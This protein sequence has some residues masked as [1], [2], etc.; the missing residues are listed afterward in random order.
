MAIDS[1]PR[2]ASPAA[3]RRRR[4]FAVEA[5]A[6][7]LLAGVAVFA[8]TEFAA[9]LFRESSWPVAAWWPSTAVAVLILVGVRPRYWALVSAAIAIGNAGGNFAV[10]TSAGLAVTFG[11]ANGVEAVIAVGV[12]RRVRRDVR[13]PAEVARLLFS[14]LT[15]VA[16][17]GVV[18]AARAAVVGGGDARRLVGELVVSHA[19]GLIVLA[20]ALLVRPQTTE[21]WEGLRRGRRRNAEWALVF[22]LTAVLTCWLFF[23]E[24]DRGLALLL[25]VP[26]VYAAVRLTP[27][28]VLSVVVLICTLVTAG[29]VHGDGVVAL[30]DGSAERLWSLRAVVAVCCLISLFVSLNAHARVTVRARLRD[31][32]RLVALAFDSAPSGMYIASLDPERAGEL[33]NVNAALCELLM[34]PREEL[35]GKHIDVLAPPDDAALARSRIAKMVGR[36][37]ADESRERELLRADGRRLPTREAVNVVY[38]ESGT[39]YV[40]GQ[41]TDLRPQQEAHAALL[42]AFDT[43]RK[44]L[45]RLREATESRKAAVRSLSHDLRSPL[46]SVRAYQEL[47]L[48]GAAGE[49]QGEQREMLEIAFRNTD[50]VIGLVDDLATAAALEA[51]PVDLVS[52]HRIDFDDVLSAAL[53]TTQSLCTRRQQTLVRQ[54]TPLGVEVEGDAVQLE[55]ALLNVL[56]NAVKYTPE[57]GTVTV[58]AVVVDD[59]LAV[60]VSDTGIGIPAHQLSQLGEQFFRADSARQEGIP[61]TGLGL[62]VT[63]AILAQHGGAMNVTS[64]ERGS[65]FTLMLP[66]AAVRA[67]SLSI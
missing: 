20:P 19:V 65:T 48:D 58:A 18:L 67:G 4:G 17:A 2:S 29:T 51:E 15:G 5:A 44:V 55:R 26:L 37:L 10:G 14:C 32:E 62:A 7:A 3:L 35:V 16:A 24:T 52:R 40:I 41:L 60:A 38:P 8:L 61:G 12:F 64:S 59:T 56:S 47:L 13:S 43:Q 34:R 6:P 46:T 49:L 11:I 27:L 57:G 1:T 50:R 36:R 42:D 53:D 21:E 33:L 9:S 45:A 54:V 63:K 22:A 25:I 30:L 23:T 39:P 66:V 31:S 28:R